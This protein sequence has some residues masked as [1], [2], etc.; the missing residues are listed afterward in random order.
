MKKIKEMGVGGGIWK[1]YEH[2]VTN[3]VC[4][5]WEKSVVKEK[6]VD[7]SEVCET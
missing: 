2:T 1:R 3:M 7:K 5:T 6:F 4:K